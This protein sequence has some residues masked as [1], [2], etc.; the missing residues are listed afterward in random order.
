MQRNAPRV[1]PGWVYFV[2]L[3]HPTA[4]EVEDDDD[5]DEDERRWNA[6]GAI[7]ARTPLDAVRSKPL[8]RMQLD[9][10]IV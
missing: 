7:G 5:E 6:D 3:I 4:F 8:Y 1:L 9:G 2:A 10:P